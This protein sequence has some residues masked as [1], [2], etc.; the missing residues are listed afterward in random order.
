MGGKGRWEKIPP[1]S[2]VLLLEFFFFFDYSFIASDNAPNSFSPVL[3]LFHTA[4]WGGDHFE[5][6]FTDEKGENV[7]N[8]P[9]DTR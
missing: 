6:H 2:F 9:K 7:S 8:F 4:L 1:G 5:P 3:N